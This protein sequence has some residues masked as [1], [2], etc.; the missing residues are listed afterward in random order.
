MPRIRNRDGSYL[1]QEKH[2]RVCR[3]PITYMYEGFTGR[4]RAYERDPETNELVKD[5]SGSSIEHYPLCANIV[6]EA[7]EA[8]WNH[9]RKVHQKKIGSDDLEKIKSNVR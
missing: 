3:K 7:I 9:Y 2:C 1:D 6:E 8:Q 4:L 5:E